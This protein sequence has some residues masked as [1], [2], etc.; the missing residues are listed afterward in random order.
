MGVFARLAD[1]I[2]ANINSMLDKAEDPEK[3]LRL[4]IQEME[5]TLIQ[6]RASTAQVLADKKQIVR[7]IDGLE[8]RQLEWQNKAELALTHGRD[9]LAK[10]ALNEKNRL[11]SDIEVQRDELNQVEQS[12]GLLQDEIEQL[13]AKLSECRNRQNA[14]LAREKAVNNRYRVRTQLDSNRAHKTRE[15]FEQFRS[16]IDQ[17]EAK[18]ELYGNS[19]GAESDLNKA[20]ED[21]ESDAKVDEELAALKAQMNA[22]KQAEQK[23][24]DA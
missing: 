14:L 6:V 13:E 4:I 24:D 9:D 11:A 5:D 19:A 18:A 1:I 7:V 23:E 20:F 15:K 3:M 10:A 21:L 2:N 16:K 12:L 22:K 17:M 8:Q